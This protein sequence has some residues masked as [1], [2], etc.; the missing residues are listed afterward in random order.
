MMTPH[1]AHLTACEVFLAFELLLA[2]AFVFGSVQLAR[3]RGLRRVTFALCVLSLLSLLWIV[4][5]VPQTLVNLDAVQLRLAL[6]SWS[7]SDGDQTALDELRD[8]IDE[9]DLKAL[10]YGKSKG[11]VFT[12]E[13]SIY[14]TLI[15]IRFEAARPSANLQKWISYVLI[16]MAVVIHVAAFIYQITLSAHDAK[17]SATLGQ[18][19]S[20][21]LSLYV[22][23]VDNLLSWSFLRS[24]QALSANLADASQPPP[25]G[26]FLATDVSPATPT[27]TTTN[28][29]PTLPVSRSNDE[30][31][32]PLVSSFPIVDRTTHSPRSHHHRAEIKTTTTPTPTTIPKSPSTPAQSPVLYLHHQH[33]AAIK[34]GRRALK[35]LVA[36]CVVSFLNLFVYAIQ[37]VVTDPYWGVTLHVVASVGPQLQLGCFMGFLVVVRLFLEVAH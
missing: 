22:L 7:D 15:L 31:S 37:L 36:L 16:I 8:K 34:A 11:V 32:K 19:A 5:L 9:A 29:S 33:H 27:A 23:S 35:L 12:L 20:A 24:V 13:S 14:V 26:E 17:T 4:L 18:I 21:A 3:R 25:E 10:Y 2:T 1:N 30:D 28:F 6:A